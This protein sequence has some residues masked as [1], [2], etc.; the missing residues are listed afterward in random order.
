MIRLCSQSPSRA[1]ILKN[2]GVSFIQSPVDFEDMPRE[3]I[4]LAGGF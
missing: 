1:R 4:L 2:A 3:E